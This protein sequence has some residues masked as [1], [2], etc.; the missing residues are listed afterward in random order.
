MDSNQT[1]EINWMKKSFFFVPCWCYVGAG[2]GVG[3][4]IG[5]GIWWL[6]QF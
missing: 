5:I 2:I 1:T 6:K 4:G 3:I